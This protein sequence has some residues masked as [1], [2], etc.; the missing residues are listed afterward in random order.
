[1]TDAIVTLAADYLPR[2]EEIGVDWK[3]LLFALGAAFVASALSCLAPLWQAVQTAPADVLGEGVRASAGARSRR[4]S[5]SLVAAEIGLAFAL[6]AVGAVLIIHVRN[7]SRISPGFDAD[8]LLTFVLSVPGSIAADSGKRIPLQTRLVEAIQTIPG[9]DQVAFAN[10]LPLD[11]CCMGTA[12][13]PEGRPVDPSASQRT[14]LMAVSSE[15]LRTMR[16]PLRSGRILSDSDV[17]PERRSVAVLIS[18]GA[19]RRYWEGQDPLGAYGRF[20]NPSGFPF[21]VVGVVGDVKNNGLGNPA[22]PEIYIPA[23]FTR[24]ETMNFVVRSARPPASLVPDIRRTVQSID[25]EQPIHDVVTMR[26]IILQA[27]TL[28]RAGSFMTAFFA[29]AALLLATLGVY[30]VVSYSVR[31]R[32]VEIGTRMALG[33]TNRDVL[34]LVVGGGL[35]MAALGVLAGGIAATGAA[36]YLGR[37]FKMGELGLSPFVYSTAIVVAVTLA[38][39]FLAAWRAALLSPMVAIRNEPE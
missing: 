32:T 12:I 26:E 19:A 31:Q 33:A 9:V 10:Q 35:K 14:S 16:I 24:V 2:A 11:G 4:V 15:Y 21:Q 13:Y 1:L 29:V 30:G 22:V 36:I 8:Q 6:L 39:S 28:E 34:F 7:L 17:V 18:E 20:D 38:A 37:V 25:P 5:Q 3:V 27:M 23:F